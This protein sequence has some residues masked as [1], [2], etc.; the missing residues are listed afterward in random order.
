ML[1]V[2]TATGA[3]F[4]DILVAPVPMAAVPLGAIAWDGAHLH[5]VVGFG[6]G[7]VRLRRR[8]DGAVTLC[9]GQLHLVLAT[10]GAK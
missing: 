7:A 6:L 2:T 1:D 3:T 4:D 10:R 8:L 9:K 5:D